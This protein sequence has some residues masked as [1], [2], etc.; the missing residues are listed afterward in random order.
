MAVAPILLR[1]NLNISRISSAVFNTNKTLDESGKAATT[2]GQTLLKRNIKKRE[3][4]K[5]DKLLFI[6]R[7]EAVRRKDRE[8][9]IEA[10]GI[11]GAIKRQANVI[12]ESTKGFLGRIMDFVGTLL[13]GWLVNN[14]PTII[15]LAQELI[16]RI[17]KF[18]EI[19]GSFVN[20]TFRIFKTFGDTLGAIYK[21]VSSFDITFTN[22]RSQVEKSMNELDDAFSQ[23]NNSFDE[24]LRL[25]T[26][27]FTTEE[28][29]GSY[30]EQPIPE[31]GSQWDGGLPPSESAEMYRIAAAL[32]T[33]GTGSQSSADM[34]QVVVNRKA[35]GRYGKTYTDILAAGQS[36][37]RSQFQGVWKR[38]GGPTEFR[39]IQTL[40]D[41]AKW[42]GQSKET[43]LKIIKDIQNPSLQSNA[44]KH[45]GGALEF[46]SSAVRYPRLAGS[47]WRGGSGDNQF[48]LDPSKDPIRKE[49]ASP[50]NLP[51]PISS[52]ITN[53]GITTTVRDEINVS[54]PRGG[55][56]LVGLTSGQGFGAA[57]RGGRRHE[58]IDI[59]TSGQRGYYVALRKTGRVVFSGV[60]G[61]YGITVDIVGP[62]GTC[63][64]FAHLAK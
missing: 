24:A 59:G 6:R 10:S 17:Q 55:T 20:N 12:A 29:E 37:K 9:I 7:R 44:A 8:S 27:P 63:Y 43:L 19:M 47:A 2:L 60:A 39:K 45:V 16:A 18:V 46:R 54:G 30:S 3:A 28:G 14:L 33:E 32:S 35:T 64:R 41:A 36:V 53:R 52:Q 50:F 5:Q 31:T 51:A 48:L 34:M 57:R 58:G 23:L 25:F 61:G 1:T 13:V 40:E 4:I 56:P 21:D 15:G 42:S 22:T 11:G 38:P 26:T 62:D 49:G